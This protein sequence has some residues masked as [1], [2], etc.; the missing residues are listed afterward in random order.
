MLRKQPIVVTIP[1]YKTLTQVIVN[2]DED[3]TCE[4]DTQLYCADTL[5][6]HSCHIVECMYCASLDCPHAEPF[7]YH[8]DGCPACYNSFSED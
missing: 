6:T 1:D 8:H 5:N 2:M 4:C 3:Y 7:H